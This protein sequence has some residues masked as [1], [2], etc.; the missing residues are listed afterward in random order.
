MRRWIPFCGWLAFLTCI[1]WGADTGGLRRF[2]DWYERLHPLADKAGHVLLIGGLT[3]ALH[4]ALGGRSVT[5]AGLP[6]AAP[7]VF[8]VMTLEEC[9]QR[10]LP[11]RTFDPYD[12]AANYA[13][14]LLAILLAGIPGR[15]RPRA[16]AQLT[17]RTR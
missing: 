10:W 8:L 17:E 4:H 2:F 13:G 12:L 1:V 11:S 15:G 3:A 6:A 9:S 7:V 16:A 5:R 14:I